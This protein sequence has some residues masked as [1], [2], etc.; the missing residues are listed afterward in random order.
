MSCMLHKA[1]EQYACISINVFDPTRK[2]GKFHTALCSD[3]AVQF[4]YNWMFFSHISCGVFFY[5][6]PLENLGDQLCFT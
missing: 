1:I 5:Y 3:L 6:F 4:I 2:S